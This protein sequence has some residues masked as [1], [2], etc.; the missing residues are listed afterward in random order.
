MS[1]GRV[2]STLTQLSYKWIGNAR[3]LSNL[4][5]SN[6]RDEALW[7]NPPKKQKI[8]KQTNKQTENKQTIPKTMYQNIYMYLS[9]QNPTTATPC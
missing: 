4:Q 8:N 2:L 6:S 7:V 3:E 1:H 5:K 9:K